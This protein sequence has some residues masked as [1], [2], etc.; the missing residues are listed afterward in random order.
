MSLT[1][2]DKYTSIA[3]MNGA[4]EEWF[5]KLYY[6]DESNYIGFGF[7]SVV[8]GG[9]QFYGII[10]SI[11]DI[12]HS[13]DLKS[14]TASIQNL[15]M[16]VTD[17]WKSGTLSEEIFK[18][19]TYYLNRKVE[20]YSILSTSTPSALTDGFIIYRGIFKGITDKS[21][22]L[23]TLNFEQKKLGEGITIPADANRVNNVYPPVAYGD[24][25]LPLTIQ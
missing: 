25:E 5:V 9:V 12:Y 8:V 1:L 14:M 13:M 10:E 21:N 3:R 22:G 6:D 4:T 19:G 20:I 24:F 2:P 18:A 16:T 15:E 7:R 11:D 17:K 23:L